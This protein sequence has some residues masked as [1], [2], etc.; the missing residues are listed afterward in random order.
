MNRTT[1]RSLDAEVGC[2]QASIFKEIRRCL[3]LKGGTVDANGI[4][5]VWRSAVSLA[6]LFGVNEKTIRR[7]LKALVSLGWLKRD[8]LQRKWGWQVYHYSLGDNAPLKGVPDQPGQKART[9]ADMVSASINSKTTSQKIHHQRR[10]A[11]R[12]SVSQQPRT[13]QSR[14]VTAKALATTGNCCPVPSDWPELDLYATAL[15]IENTRNQFPL[16]RRRAVG[17][18]AA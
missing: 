4:K 10:T 2:L 15:A 12:P 9:D 13:E 5:W 7:H 17:F 11:S 14:V 8:K 6:D 1:Y 18:G 16:L 3:R